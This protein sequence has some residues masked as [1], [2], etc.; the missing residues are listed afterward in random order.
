MDDPTQPALC[1]IHD[2]PVWRVAGGGGNPTVPERVRQTVMRPSL[3]VP[4]P[5]LL[6]SNRALAARGHEEA[7]GRS[8]L[9]H[10]GQA[11]HPGAGAD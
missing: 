10:H 1:P 5:K 11:R 8:A 6:G 9:H 7:A 4:L 3:A 2:S